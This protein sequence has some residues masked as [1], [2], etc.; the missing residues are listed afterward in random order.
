MF[1][2]FPISPSTYHKHSWELFTG[3]LHW[4]HEWW[5]RWWVEEGSWHCSG[6]GLGISW[7]LAFC[8]PR[9]AE[10]QLGSIW[11]REIC[12]RNLCD[13][14]LLE[15][16]NMF[17]DVLCGPSLA[18]GGLELSGFVPFVWAPL[19]FCPGWNYTDAD[20]TK[21]HGKHWQT[22]IVLIPAKHS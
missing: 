10:L 19:V 5:R 1:S 4:A 14:A 17:W 12:P 7:R 20:L 2:V 21:T 16:W 18:K 9:V 13:L 3:L 15:M 11:P 6:R 22:M 8:W